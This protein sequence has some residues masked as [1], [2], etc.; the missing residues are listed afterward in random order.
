M[1]RAYE[2]LL[3]DAHPGVVVVA[4]L[5]GKM[6]LLCSEKTILRA[7]R[8]HGIHFKPLYEKPT[9]DKGA[10]AKRLERATTNLHRSPT[11]WN[12]FIHAV[13]GNQVFPM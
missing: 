4:M 5:K 6:G 1:L 10:V 7:F 3:K 2:K 12:S 13:I 11:Q 9:I 8:A